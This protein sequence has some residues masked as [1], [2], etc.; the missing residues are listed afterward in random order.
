MSLIKIAFAQTSPLNLVEFINFYC[1]EGLELNY[2]LQ[3]IY[4]LLVAIAVLVAFF[5]FL[6][7]AFENL[8]STIPD[9]KKQGKDRMK[10]A[11]IGLVIIFLSGVVLYWINPYI[12]NAR[13]ILYKVEKL[14]IRQELVIIGKGTETSGLPEIEGQGINPSQSGIQYN[15]PLIKQG[16]PAWANIPYRH[17][18]CGK[19]SQTIKSSGCGIASLAMAIAYYNNYTPDKYYNLIKT[20]AKDAVDQGYRTCDSGTSYALYTDNTYLR[21][22]NIK[23]VYIGTDI[24]KAINALRNNKIVIAA[25]R[26][27]SR[28]TARGHYI[29]LVGFNNNKFLI[30]DPG[31]RDVKDSTKEEFIKFVKA[32]WIIYPLQ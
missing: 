8:L 4:N 27:P 26:G 31:P 16:D 1:R 9:F 18:V 10:N 14:D 17:P 7:G 2:C 11:I 32:M 15:H 21:K 13:L 5:V 23:G 3:G 30:N 29:T 22:W 19:E 12:F 28:F 25:M 20:L 24:S 6:F